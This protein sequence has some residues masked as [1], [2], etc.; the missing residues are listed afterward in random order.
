MATQRRDKWQ[1][2]LVNK[3]APTQQHQRNARHRGG[4]QKVRRFK[5]RWKNTDPL[6]CL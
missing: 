5:Q 6:R 3:T 4:T 2:G 1:D